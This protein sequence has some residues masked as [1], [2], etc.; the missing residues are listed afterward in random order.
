MKIAYLI[1]EFPGQTHIWMWREIVHLQKWGVAIQ[2]VS[3]RHP[4]PNERAR[5]A[6]A[7]E[8]LSSVEYIYDE[9]HRITTWRLILRDLLW[10]A[11]T[12]PMRFF[13]ALTFSLRLACKKPTATL[14]LLA[15]IA[16][17][18][19]LARLI[20]QGGS[21]HL[22]VHSFGK[23][24]L[25]AILAKRITGISFS[26]TLNAYIQIWGGFVSEKLHEA[27]FTVAITQEL[28]EHIRQEAPRLPCGKYI[29]G[30]IG[31]DTPN[32]PAD[33]WRPQ[34]SGQPFR[35]ITVGRLHP[36]KGHDDLIR[37][38]AGL[39]NQGLNVVLAILGDGPQRDDLHRLANHLGIADRVVFFG[40]V[41]E[42]EIKQQMA[43]SHCFVGASHC[44]PLGVV[45]MEAMAAGLPTIGTAAGGLQEIID[46]ERSGL[47]V[48]P[49]D[50]PAL[51]S[52]IR[53]LIAD[54]ALCRSLSINGRRKICDEFDSEVGAKTLM[55]KLSEILP[56]S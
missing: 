21:Q 26:Q 54:P 29:L 4:S 16:P 17:S 40:S 31:V 45:F 6:F 37:A 8:S 41:S 12:R 32:W 47:L 2:L 33:N 10:A 51:E 28:M 27:E 9:Q 36:V 42:K 49:K 23:S 30:R 22:H 24:S 44:E 53:K 48:P 34:T 56:S 43:T 3:T 11:F 18:C 7:D 5:H 13:S 46:H 1:P 35:L 25:M 14:K 38:V 55:N 20:T 52:A 15:L 19:R 50:V 39:H